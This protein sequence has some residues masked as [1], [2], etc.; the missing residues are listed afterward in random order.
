MR[1]S[2]EAFL[3]AVESLCRARRIRMSDHAAAMS[4]NVHR[5]W[6]RVG[7][8]GRMVENPERYSGDW[9]WLVGEI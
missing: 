6:T 5:R 1:E 3:G 7:D 8:D 9:V 4:K 2:L